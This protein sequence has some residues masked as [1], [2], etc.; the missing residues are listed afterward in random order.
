MNPP[1]PKQR[2]ARAYSLR[3]SVEEIQREI[4]EEGPVTAAFT[5]FQD[6]M[7]YS[8]GVY[9]HAAGTPLGEHGLCDRAELDVNY[10][11]M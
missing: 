11:D 6:F 9:A 3:R 10:I 2:A 8:G 5:V 4:L 7:T 1:P